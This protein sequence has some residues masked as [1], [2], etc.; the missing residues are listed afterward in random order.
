[1]NRG[2]VAIIQPDSMEDVCCLDSVVPHVL[3]EEGGIFRPPSVPQF[4][5][6]PPGDKLPPQVDIRTWH[7][8]VKNLLTDVIVILLLL[9]LLFI[10]II[11]IYY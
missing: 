11:I 1:M 4:H 6:V 2:T 5:A 3:P 7:E 10:I 9:L 8:I